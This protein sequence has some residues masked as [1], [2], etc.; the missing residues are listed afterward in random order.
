MFKQRFTNDWR[1][2]TV[3]ISVLAVHLIVEASFMEIQM[4]SSSVVIVNI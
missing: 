2:K 3:G 4:N 1:V